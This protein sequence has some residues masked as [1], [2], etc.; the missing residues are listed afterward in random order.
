MRCHLPSFKTLIPAV[1]KNLILA[2]RA[3]IASDRVNGGCGKEAIR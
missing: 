2:V 3:K 1:F